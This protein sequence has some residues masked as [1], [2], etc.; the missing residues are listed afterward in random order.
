MC[1]G[2][3]NRIADLRAMFLSSEICTV[4]KSYWTQNY[5][6]SEEVKQRGQSRCD[7]QIKAQ[8]GEVVV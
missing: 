2:S 7:A 4:L 1:E 3:Q 8:T 5:A 6:D